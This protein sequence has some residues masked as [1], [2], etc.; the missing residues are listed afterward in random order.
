LYL[1]GVELCNGYQELTDPDE[2]EQRMQRQS[3]LRVREGLRP[4]PVKSRLLEAL[5]VTGLPSCSGV[6]LGF[7][8]LTMLALG[9]TS[10]AAVTA[11][12]IG[13]A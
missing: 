9:K 7:D 3:A 13:R 1:G 10:L 4:L 5:R 11:F 2:L 6:A 12:P 8:R